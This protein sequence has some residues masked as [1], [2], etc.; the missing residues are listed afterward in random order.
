MDHT[1]FKTISY[2][3]LYSGKNKEL[4]TFYRDVLGIPPLPAQ[5]ENHNWYGF[6]TSGVTLAIEPET[7]RQNHSFAY[8][9]NNPILIQFKANDEAHLEAMNQQLEKMGVTLLKRAEKRSY[10]TITNFVDPDGN[11][12]EILL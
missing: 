6:G 7:N 3:N 9:K 10:G 4:I 12:L 1:L 5:D 8:N 11:L 2:I